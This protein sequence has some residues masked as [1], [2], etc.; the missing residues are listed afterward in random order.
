MSTLTILDFDDTLAQTDVHISMPVRASLHGLLQA[1]TGLELDAFLEK[2]AILSK[3]YG[4]SIHGWAAVLGKD[5]RWVLKTFRALAP[6]LTDAALAGIRPDGALNAKLQ[7][8]KA[9]GH[10][11]AV[12]THGHRDYV[13]PVMAHLGLLEVIPEQNVFDIESTE[14]VLKR[15]E[16]A[17]RYVLNTL[18]DTVFLAHNMVEDSPLNLVAPKKMGFTTWLVGHQVPTVEATPYIDHRLPTIHDVV[19]ALLVKGA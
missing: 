3:Q 4:T 15:N 16:D 13:L 17:Y 8:L 14:G 2:T 11:L 18:A 6:T 19:N 12:L 5:T 7:T 9:K 10:T 1:E